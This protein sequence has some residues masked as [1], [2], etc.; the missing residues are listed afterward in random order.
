MVY[1]IELKVLTV[2]TACCLVAMGCTSV[3][4]YEYSDETKIREVIADLWAS[5]EANDLERIYQTCPKLRD[6]DIDLTDEQ[7][8]ERMVK[9]RAQLKSDRSK[10]IDFATVIRVDIDDTAGDALAFVSDPEK[11]K[12]P[13]WYYLRKDDN[14]WTIWITENWPAVPVADLFSK[15]RKSVDHDGTVSNEAPR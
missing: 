2:F 6:R 14:D 1:R 5:V 12:Q 4:R 8:E 15:C 11:E 10:G 7:L 9:A 3:H 13:F